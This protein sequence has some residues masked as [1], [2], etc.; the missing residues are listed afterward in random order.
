M[1]NNYYL[2]LL[3]KKVR[4]MKKVLEELD[5]QQYSSDYKKHLISGYIIT[6]DSI[7]EIGL[8]DLH[9]SDLDELTSLIYYTRQKAVHYGYF[10][11]LHNIDDTA[12][13]IIELAESTYEDEQRYYNKLFSYPFDEQYNNIVIKNSSRIEEDNYFYKFTSKDHSKVL[14]VPTRRIFKLTQ[15]S[16]EKVNDYIVDTTNPI[17][18]YS[19]EDGILGNYKEI[20]EEEIREF[21]KENFYVT[22]ENYNE[23][24]IVM[25]NIIKSFVTDPINS[26]HIIEFVSDEQFCRNTIDVIKEFILDYSMYSEYINNNHLIKE[27]HSLNKIQKAD[28]AKL[29]KALRKNGFQYLNEKDA[30]FIQMA[31]KRFQCYSN[32]IEDSFDCDNF[33][34]ETLAP[35]LIQLFETGPKHF[36]NKF[37]NSSPEFKK[38]YTNLLRYRQIFSHY[39]IV[40]KEY[41]DGLTKFRDEFINFIGM[42]Q[43]IDISQVKINL[44]EE[45]ETYQI[46]ERDKSDFFNYKHEQFLRVY[47]NAY[48][49][50][51]IYYSSHTPDSKS[52]IAII[53]G[54]HNASNTL[55]YKK[56]LNGYIYP[57]YTI[58]EKTGKKKYT[59]L[60]TEPLHSAKDVRI[61]LNLT[62]LF[63]AYSTLNLSKKGK[64]DIY[65]F[66]AACE[67]N[68]NQ[69]HYDNLET[70]I[71]RFF[72][73]GYLPVELLQRTMLNCSDI[74]KGSIILT[75]PHGNNIATIVNKQKCGIEPKTKKDDKR[76][77]S[78]ID[79]ITHDFSKRRHRK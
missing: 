67:E 36:S 26:V 5:S 63:K 6:L 18:L 4:E 9:S 45:Y 49:G 13:K 11:G 8:S 40:G 71:L 28:Y 34:F 54:G 70:V 17:A 44:K 1:N 7:L 62:N 24:N 3:L 31:T 46:I 23:H 25:K 37:I 53:P 42:L 35:I 38:C 29:Q 15:R 75:D 39:I 43:T 47:K 16:K 59:N 74:S 27:K 22:S 41:R 51:K 19:Y 77:F 66:F 14:C 55:Y 73:Q 50:K 58:D 78:R 10:N 30:F 48:I 76:F 72:I 32:I 68:N 20:D 2:S 57:E 64:D 61:D 60:S 12:N 56:D 69:A 79:D 33:K 21:F 52:L 65:I